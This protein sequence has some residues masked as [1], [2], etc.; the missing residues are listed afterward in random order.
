MTNIDNQEVVMA[1]KTNRGNMIG[2][3][4]LVTASWGICHLRKES[5]M[6]DI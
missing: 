2:M 5:Q 6:S 1:V 4:F 3:D